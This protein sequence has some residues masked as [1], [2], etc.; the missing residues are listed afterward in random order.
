MSQ[1]GSIDIRMTLSVFDTGEWVGIKTNVKLNEDASDTAIVVRIY[2]NEIR[3]VTEPSGTTVERVSTQAVLPDLGTLFDPD[4]FPLFEI[5]PEYTAADGL[6]F[7]TGETIRILFENNT[8]TIY[9]NNDYFH[10]FY[11][12]SIF[13]PDDNDPDVYLI[14]SSG[15][16]VFPTLEILLAELNDWRESI[17]IESDNVAMSGVSDLIQERPIIILARPDGSVDFF[18]ERS[19]N[20]E[21]SLHDNIIHE[22]TMDE[23]D[24]AAAVEAI[25][26]GREL[27]AIS[28]PEYAEEMGYQFSTIHLNSLDTGEKKAARII[29]KRAVEGAV[30]HSLR[31][32]PD[33]R[34]EPDDLIAISPEVS[35]TGTILDHSIVVEELFVSINNE[36]AIMSIEGRRKL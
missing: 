26:E 21:Y 20:I 8:I 19:T 29:L 31:I 16:A 14:C 4:F 32:R 24:V 10:T 3:V 15:W 9:R 17:Y 25:V 12:P 2:C 27:M 23:V 6:S 1:Y 35:G 7:E 36:E 34:I 5:T 28:L 30:H 18:Y 33:V 22:H 13:Y 11:L